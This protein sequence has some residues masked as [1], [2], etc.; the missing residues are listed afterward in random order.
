VQLARR[1]LA[2]PGG[3]AR[4]VFHEPLKRY[5][6]RLHFDLGTSAESVVVKRQSPR[7]AR[8]NELVAKRWLPAVGLAWACPSVRGRVVEPGARNVWQVYEDLGGCG[9]DG[10]PADL[11][12][13][14]AVVELI[15]QLHTRFGLHPLLSECRR[16]GEGLGMA[17]YASRVVRCVRDLGSLAARRGLEHPEVIERLRGRFEQLRDERRDRAML[18][19]RLGGP[20]TL[21][22]G[23]LWTTNTLVVEDAGRVSARLI[24]WDHAG[25]GPAS[26]D[27][28]TFLYRFDSTDRPW[29]LRLYREAVA[30][31]GWEVPSDRELNLLFETAECARYASCAAEAA[32]WACR[33]AGWGFAQLVEIDRWFA[34]LEPVL[35][36]EEAVS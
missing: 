18:M 4:L 15:A 12:R 19:A 27:L 20:A 36:V 34:D 2:G 24:D 16:A 9:L 30:Q 22:H 33:G 13:V 14:G 21:L 6:H 17:F 10:A 28:S 11:A 25:V 3:E 5:V 35:V 1:L 7:S 23:D 32:R 29:I 31:D 26:Y 8:V